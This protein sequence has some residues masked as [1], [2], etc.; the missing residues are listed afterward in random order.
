MKPYF[1]LNSPI[2]TPAAIWAL[3][4]S[5]LLTVFA[6]YPGLRGDFIF[7]DF[8]NLLNNAALKV[9]SL[10]IRD[11]WAAA[12]SSE[13]GMLRRPVSMFTFAVNHYFSGF[14][15]LPYKATNLVIHLLCGIAL[16]TLGR[17][18]LKTLRTT[19]D[20]N[21]SDAAVRWIPLVVAA[22]WLVHPLNLT[23]VLYVVQ[24]MTSL[25][26]LFSVLALI[27]FLR[28]RWA[29]YDGQKKYLKA[30]IAG[31]FFT[32]L[33]VLS[34]ENGALVPVFALLIEAATFRGRTKT[35]N[36]DKR[37][38]LAFLVTV[39]VPA[40]SAL[41]YLATHPEY[42]TNA[43]AG[44]PFTLSERLLTESRVIF[45]YLNSIVLPKV[46]ELGLYHDDFV[47]STSLLS[48]LSTSVALAGIAA[49]ISAGV[50]LL[51]SAPLI[52]VG[53]LW[54]FAGH[55]LE[56]TA[57]PLELVYE[58]RNYLPSYGILLTLTYASFVLAKQ[59][60]ILGLS[61]VFAVVSI[62]MLASV[63][64]VRAQQW[65][66]NV[67]Q[68][69]TEAQ[70]HPNSA[71]AVYGAG[72]IYAN[73]YLTGGLDNPQK[74]F[75]TL[76]RA[77]KLDL[78]SILPSAA[79][80][81]LAAKTEREMHPSWIQSLITRL[82]DGPV[83]PSTIATLKIMVT[84][85]AT[86][87]SIGAR[88]IEGILEAALAN[89]TVAGGKRADLL[90]IY[91]TYKA[92]SLGDFDTARK[93]FSEAVAISPAELRYRINLTQLLVAVGEL[94]AATISLDEAAQIDSLGTHTKELSALRKIIAD[95][96]ASS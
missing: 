40:V 1:S 62:L 82:E 17:D 14:D 22:F 18:L 94:D 20:A 27:A 51:R 76:E 96:L 37:V 28:C 36:W 34:K 89:P 86:V 77:R 33:A 64:F 73:L 72:R 25:S 2:Y 26:A 5:L 88:H 69:I 4:G 90:T 68:A 85:S 67:T 54:Y 65:E 19:Q 78:E 95:R 75:D 92:N 52:G 31:I 11:F 93:M 13:S 41:G 61:R 63:T 12:L 71:R 57:I 87:E 49:L 38:I 84:D 58:H 39:A 8:P 29:L 70:N 53:V 23:S 45:F 81:M 56:S 42:L 32:L 59:L 3:M 47:R 55:S 48:P 35:G 10:S 6:Y 16:L 83:T 44:R 79:L 80:I 66:D 43:Y 50:Y 46:S 74:A 30:F 60:Q 9:E 7:D 21:L 24:R 15:P 91:G